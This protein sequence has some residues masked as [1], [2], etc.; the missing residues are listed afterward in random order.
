MM[1]SEFESDNQLT[2]DQLARIGQ[3]GSLADYFSGGQPRGSPN[4]VNPS[5]CT[6]AMRAIEIHHRAHDA[7]RH[8]GTH[9][10]HLMVLHD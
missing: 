10:A 6:L 9:A 4:Q 8:T 5:I 3:T 1:L 2:Q 7:L